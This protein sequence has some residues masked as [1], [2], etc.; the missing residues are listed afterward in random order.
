MKLS[1]IQHVLAVADA[2]SLRGGS[3]ELG[4]TQPCMSRSIRDT[5]NEL[6][7]S[8]FTRH[9][10]GVTLTPMGRLFVQRATA[11]QS[12]IRR[13]GEE[14]EQAKGQFSGQ[15]AVAMSGAASVALLPSVL[16]KFETK[17]PGALL[18]LTESLFQPVEKQIHSGEIDFFVGPI[19]E[20][21]TKTSLL[22]EK[23]FDNYRIIVMRK[24]HPLAGAKTLS[25]LRTARWIQPSFAH[26]RDESDFGAMFESAGLPP[27]EIAVRMNSAM[28]LMLAVANTDLL[29][30]LP[31]QWL[32]MVVDR[33]QIDFVQLPEVMPAAPVCIV[34]RGDLPLTPLAERLCDITRAAGLNYGR[35]LAQRR[36]AGK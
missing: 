15:V 10:H 30:I 9:G 26:Q 1:N 36:G 31:I 3:R 27:P 21:L 32:D 28:M 35:K 25:D 22:I 23:L 19:Y 5:E 33:S 18:K 13:L 7:V 8:L 34:R 29:T 24:G 11:I 17:Y 14:I 4:I 20:N 12:E 6:G 16:K 2:G